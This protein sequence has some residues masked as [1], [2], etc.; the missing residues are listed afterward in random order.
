MA[1]ILETTRLAL[2]PAERSDAAFLLELMNEPGYIKN[3]GDREVRTVG[4]AEAYIDAKFSESYKTLGFGLWIV[5]TKTE[6]TAL[7]ICG[8]IKR[9]ALANPDLGFA[10]LERFWSQGY[11]YESAAAVLEYGCD[12]LGLY[13]VFAVTSKTNRASIRLLEKLGFT[14][15]GTIVL[16]GY[17]EESNLFSLIFPRDIPVGAT[18]GVP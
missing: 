13:Q 9:D 7:G 3:I 11:G 15:N 6:A 14:C 10:Y 1:F 4:D 18:A 17:A 2:R 12:T 16:P 8:F 5:E